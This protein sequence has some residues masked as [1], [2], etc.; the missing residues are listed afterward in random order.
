[1][2]LKALV[3]SYAF[4]PTGGAGVQRVLKLVKYL[5][6][7]GVTPAVLTAGNPSVP[8]RDPSLLAELPAGLEVIRA[9]TLEPGYRLKHATWNAARLRSRAASLARA[10]CLPDPQVL[11]QPAAQA[12]LAR[13]LFG[14]E[15]D[16][17]VL[18]SGPPF[19][20]F[21]LAP[22]TRLR[23]PTALVL[24]YRDEWSTTRSTYEMA[25]RAANA[26]GALLE[27]RLLR[28]ADAV[29]TATEEFRAELLSRFAFLDSARVVAIPNGYDPADFSRSL[30]EPPAGRFVV[31]YAGTVFRLTTARWL[32]DAVRLL[33]ERTPE[34][35]ELLRVRFIGRIVETE[36]EPFEQAPG[37]ERLGYRP[38]AEVLAEL[39]SSHLTLCLLDELPGAERIY[40]AKIFELMR[41]G[42]PCLVLSPEGAL[43]RLV[44]RHRAG[45][46]V[47]PR[48]PAAIA[49]ALARRLREFA[50]G[51]APE[52][53]S[54][55]G[56]ERYDRWR[57]AGEFAAVL[58]QAR[59]RA[60][61]VKPPVDLTLG[62]TELDAAVGH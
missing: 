47:A 43:A 3:V 45:E 16:D 27:P 46:L 40:P 61:G 54:S 30:P 31:S 53:A 49:D 32:L 11:W 29:T 7:H 59:E 4:P 14:R 23:R 38:H 1:M 35:A 18:I 41:L 52:R 58:R 20:Q 9:R 2:T 34:L 17:V 5:P 37:V 50:D 21:L 44:R 15:R 42:R 62:D 51:R 55:V 36:L 25:G 57:L 24:D 60:S 19:S 13:R 6:A 22:L 33:H 12:A 28:L 26:A 8:V 39:A 56:I 10:C 48:D